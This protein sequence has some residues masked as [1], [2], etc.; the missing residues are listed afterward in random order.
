MHV[1]MVLVDITGVV[2]VKVGGVAINLEQN[3]A[4]QDRCMSEVNSI[5]SPWHVMKLLLLENAT[6]VEEDQL[7]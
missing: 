2:H 6:M 1:T 7:E 3:V 4:L 5:A